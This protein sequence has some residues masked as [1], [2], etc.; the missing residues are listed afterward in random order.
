MEKKNWTDTQGPEVLFNMKI[1]LAFHLEINASG[2]E[3][4]WRTTGSV[5]LSVK[6]QVREGL[7]CKGI[8]WCWCIVCSEVHSQGSQEPLENFMLPSAD[9]IC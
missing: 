9:V 7:G 3:E 4:E 8:C 2:L 6:F 1:K 5:L